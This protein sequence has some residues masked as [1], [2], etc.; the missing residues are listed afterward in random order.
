MS[1]VI[2]TLNRYEYLKDVLEDLERQEYTN[3]EVIVVDQSLPFQDEFYRKFNL[4]MK[5]V[6]QKKRALWLARNHAIE[7]SEG[8][9][10]LLFDDD[11]RVKSDWITNHLKCI[12]FFD[13]DIS[14]GVSISTVGAEVPKNYSFF[15]ISDQIDT[16]NVLLKKQIFREIG[17]FDRQ[18][19]KQ[20]MG[21][22][23]F[24]LRAYLNNYKNVSNP[25]A[26]RIHLKV[27]SG[28]LREMGSWDAFRPKKW[29][30]PRPVPSVLYLFR[31]YYG[32]KLS[33][34]SL[35]KTLPPAIIPYQFKKSKKG[36]ILGFVLTV[37][38]F[39]SSYSRY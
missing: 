13:A 16:G 37:L 2:P 24:G 39:P 34:L 17:L 36:M 33:L 9:Y 15:R 10:I 23:E 18:F 11:S 38:F 6:Q 20:R 19:E 32:T 31:K 12:D 21:D 5:V 4:K 22:G 8:E 1:V 30:G 35:L 25:Y 3:F 27:G 7:I 29:F 14:S 28:G 26:G